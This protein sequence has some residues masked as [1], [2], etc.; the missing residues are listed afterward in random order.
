MASKLLHKDLDD[1][2]LL[3]MMEFAESMKSKEHDGIP[4][5]VDAEGFCRLVARF[6]SHDES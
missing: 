4:G 6:S 2:Q 5:I 1:E 3:A